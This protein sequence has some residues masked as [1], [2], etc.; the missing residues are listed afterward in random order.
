MQA[1]KPIAHETGTMEAVVVHG[2]YE[3]DDNPARVDRDA[4]WHF[5]S[6]EAY[7]A[8]WRSRADVDQQLLG[9][10]RVVGCYDRDGHMVG[11]ARA[12]SDGVDLAYLTDVYVLADHRG[13][14]LGRA[15]VQEMIDDGPGRDFRWMLHTSDAHDLYRKFGFS[16]PDRR[17]MERPSRAAGPLDPGQ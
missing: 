2:S 16:E 6:T 17:Y 10:W 15:I 5:V 4:L 3:L 8:R 11:F 1:I 13:R 12:V 14:G 7:W 9:S